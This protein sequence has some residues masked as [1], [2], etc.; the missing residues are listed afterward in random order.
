MHVAD[1]ARHMHLFANTP[2]GAQASAMIYS[3]IETAK[4]NWLDPYRYLL[5]VL[6]QAPKLFLTDRD[7]AEK[8]LPDNAPDSCRIL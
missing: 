8:L 2:L 1:S 3:L 6:E 4:E 7:W 5:W